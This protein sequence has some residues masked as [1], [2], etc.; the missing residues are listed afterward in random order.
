MACV[1]LTNC[2]KYLPFHQ[3]KFLILKIVVNVQCGNAAS[4]I[5]TIPSLQ[6][7]VEFA[8]LPTEC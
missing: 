3:L 7:W 2:M 8:S 1:V 6:D 4:A 5:A